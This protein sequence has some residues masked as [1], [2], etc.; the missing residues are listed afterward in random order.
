MKNLVIAWL[1]SSVAFTIAFVGFMLFW[2]W[3]DDGTFRSL[4]TILRLGLLAISAAFVVQLFYG[5][6]VYLALTR[7][8]LWN[9][10]VVALA[11]LLPLPVIG[12][13]VVDT[14]REAWG[15]IGWVILACIVAFVSW[16]FAPVQTRRTAG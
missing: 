1:A 9:F 13:F 7:A 15:M 8:G 2:V 12:W 5:G 4:N 6:L 11:Y 3:L 16:F 10:W 14:T